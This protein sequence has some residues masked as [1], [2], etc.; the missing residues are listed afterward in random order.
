LQVRVKISKEGLTLDE[1]PGISHCHG[2][3]VEKTLAASLVLPTMVNKK[4]LL[5]EE[6]KFF[7]GLIQPRA[8]LSEVVVK[9]FLLQLQ[10][11]AL[12]S[13]TFPEFPK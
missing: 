11:S 6:Q 9:E 4:M 1:I 10:F 3:W 2:L 5:V 12:E 7:H 13:I 8:H